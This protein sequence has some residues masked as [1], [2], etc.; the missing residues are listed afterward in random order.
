[1]AHRP[2]PVLRHYY[3]D[4]IKFGATAGHALANRIDQSRGVGALSEEASQKVSIGALVVG[5]VL[6]TIALVKGYTLLG[7]GVMGAALV[8]GAMIEKGS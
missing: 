2:L 6:G 4:A 3:D 8:G 1:M 7:V 5:G